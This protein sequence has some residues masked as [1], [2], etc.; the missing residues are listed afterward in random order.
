MW[1]TDGRDGHT[2][3]FVLSPSS[4]TCLIKQYELLGHSVMQAVSTADGKKLLT[5]N[6]LARRTLRA[7][8]RYHL[9]CLN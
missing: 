5:V 7:N 3:A 8:A 1:R 9:T 2:R 4:S 6:L